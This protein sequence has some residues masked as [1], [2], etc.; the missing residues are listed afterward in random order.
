[1]MLFELYV[2]DKLR[3]SRET[4][5]AAKESAVPFV[6]AGCNVRIEHPCA[7]APT[8]VW[9]YDREVSEWVRSGN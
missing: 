9:R 4:L 6:K 3:G 7:P 2:D 8:V 5:E 1:M